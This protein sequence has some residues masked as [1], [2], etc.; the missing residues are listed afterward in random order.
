M[1]QRQR[2]SRHHLFTVP[3]LDRSDPKAVEA[4]GRRLRVEASEGTGGTKAVE[5]GSHRGRFGVSGGH[6]S[7]M[8]AAGGMRA[9]RVEKVG[10]GEVSECEEGGPGPP[11]DYL[12][13]G[14]SGG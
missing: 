11:L 13:Y 14:L 7:W 3:G 6:I 9:P 10:E 12:D 1:Q 8:V 4:S 5:R 2:E